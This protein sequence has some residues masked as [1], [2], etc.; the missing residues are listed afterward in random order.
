[1]RS[2]HDFNKKRELSIWKHPEKV[3]PEKLLFWSWYEPRNFG[4]WIGPYLY[5]AATGSPPLFCPRERI[6]QFGCVMAVGSI[7]RHLITDD[8]VIVWGSGIMSGSDA[9]KRPKKILAVRGPLTRRRVTALGYECP[10]VYGDPAIL[11]PQCYKPARSLRLYPIGVI[12]HFVDRR[13]FCSRGDL[14]VIDPT[15][16]IDRV[17]EHI[18]S[19]KITF[20]SSLHGVI[21]S[22]AYGVPSV[23]IRSVNPIDGDDTKFRDYFQSV[24][25]DPQPVVLRSYESRDLAA[26]ES[27]ATLPSHLP[28][29]KPL[30]NSCPFKPQGFSLHDPD[31]GV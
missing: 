17:I 4:D 29:L 7:L 16:P 11:L 8:R 12:P 23:W 10:E 2:S 14:L 18:V 3:E 13:L 1:M 25:L 24:G 21:V 28:L 22:H 20:S 6:S 26:L 30:A 9:F 19:C 5:E 27:V 31:S 15:R